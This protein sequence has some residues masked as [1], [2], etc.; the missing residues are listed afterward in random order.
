MA[1]IISAGTTSGTALNMSG[2]TSGNLQ[3]QTQAGANTITVPNAT[4]TMMVSG[5]MPTFSYYQSSAQ[6][7]SGAT[8]TKITFTS[9]DWDTTSGMFA[10]SRFTPTVAGY[11][12]V[13]GAIT[14][15]ASFCGGEVLIYKNGSNFKSGAGVGGG[16]VGN[17]FTVSGLVYCNGSTDYIEIYGYVGVGQALSTGSAQTYFQAA[18]VRSA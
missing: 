14:M 13:D 16:S 17:R 3:L 7:L 10:S 11:Y 4:G 8:N 6:T 15:S 18:M 12:V 2:D 1:T 9:N 5:N